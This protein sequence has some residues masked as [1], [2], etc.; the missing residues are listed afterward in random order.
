MGCG[1]SLR[2]TTRGLGLDL[3]FPTVQ[4]FF[5]CESILHA[6]QIAASALAV[7]LFWCLT[8]FMAFLSFGDGYYPLLLTAFTGFMAWSTYD[9]IDL[10]YS[11]AHLVVGDESTWGFGQVLPML[12]ISSIG[13]QS[14]DA[15][16]AAG[17]K[18]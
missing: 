17:A 6:V 9:I 5:F 12:L 11:N 10:K 7:V 8:Q 16:T 15:W 2:R 4:W 3:R 14:I 18:P 13:F 1:I